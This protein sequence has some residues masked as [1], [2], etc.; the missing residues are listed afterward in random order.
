MAAYSVSSVITS[1][2]IL[3]ASR[4]PRSSSIILD[5]SSINSLWMRYPTWGSSILGM[6]WTSPCQPGYFIISLK[7]CNQ[8]CEA[9]PYFFLSVPLSDLKNPS[10]TARSLSTPVQILIKAA[11]VSVSILCMY[12]RPYLLAN[13]SSLIRLGQ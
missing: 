13:S 12:G 8:D 7:T 3:R 6:A 4:H 10:S 11:F 2:I 9:P 5:L 1:P